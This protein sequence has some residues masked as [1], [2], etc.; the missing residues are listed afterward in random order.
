MTLVSGLLAIPIVTGLSAWQLTKPQLCE[1]V[2]AAGSFFTLV[3][4]LTIAVQVFDGQ[5]IAGWDG[6]I[7][8]D[9]FSAYNIVLITLVG[10]IAS[11]Y[12]MGYMR[13]ELRE[14]M[15]TPKQYRGYYLLFHLFLFTM[16]SVSVVDSLGLMWV[17]IELTTLVSALLVAFY[18]NGNALEAAWKYLIMGSVGIAFA[19]LGIIFLYLSGIQTLGQEPLALHWTL[20]MQAAERL[21]PLWVEIA[22]V[23]ILIGFGTKAGL[24]PMHFWLPDA[25]S[26]APSPISAVLSGVLL[27]TALYGIFRVYAITNI[28][29]NGQA[30]QY[31]IV[32]GLLSMVI[33]VPFIMVQHDLKRMLAYSSVEHMGIITLSAGIGGSLGL[34]AAF[35]HMFN[36]S[37][38]KSLLFF[39]A[40]NI[41]QKYH[42]KQME[43]ISGLIKTMP[44][45]GG[46]F[47]IAAVAITGAPPFSLFISEFTI[48]MAGFQQGHTGP[49]V[50]FVVIIALIFAG[51]MYYVTKMVF[52]EAPAKLEKSEI[53][54]W[55]AAALFIPLAFIIVC[56]LYVPPFLDET[57]YRVSDVLQGVNR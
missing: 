30:A 29:L 38:A 14:N 2:Q 45:T 41:S 23:F 47:L 8:I 33:T 49:A 9:A 55:S 13:H 40:G 17:G 53:S 15:I 5:V 42:S 31:L 50:L 34:Y 19:L 46:I 16:L 27:N 7:H 36:H 11:L 54:F 6:F 18:R 28:T 52:G 22:F 39:S 21:N 26:Q 4:A 12:S 3:A 48:M 24:A 32:F 37:M 51:M 20:L 57:I 10:F 25:H 56:G 44:V 1:K 43:R 35:L